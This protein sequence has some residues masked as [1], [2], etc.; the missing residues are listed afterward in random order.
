MEIVLWAGKI[1]FGLNILNHYGSRKSQKMNCQ[2]NSRWLLK[3]QF[4]PWY[5]QL[6]TRKCAKSYYQQPFLYF[7]WQLLLPF[8]SMSEKNQSQWND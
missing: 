3:R 5:K 2:V 4:I 8:G 6:P 1:Y 7:L